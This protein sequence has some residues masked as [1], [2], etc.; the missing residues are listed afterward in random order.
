[1]D[2][3]AHR[4]WTPTLVSLSSER[5][6]VR[7]YRAVPFACL[8]P[9]Q[10]GGAFPF[11]FSWIS[12]NRIGVRAARPLRSDELSD[13]LAATTGV[14]VNIRAATSGPG[15]FLLIDVPA[16][17]S[18]VAEAAGR[19]RMFSFVVDATE[20]SDD[21]LCVRSD[22]APPPACPPWHLALW[23]PFSYGAANG[24]TVL[25]S[26]GGVVELKYTDASGVTS[27][28]SVAMPK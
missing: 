4:T 2:S 19:A 18:A 8:R 10:S 5:M 9:K 13:L 23:V 14:L 16:G 22:V 11:N 27:S 25:V 24:D 7:E 12:C 3:T 28:V 26:S 1:M 21:P 20:V 17:E 15:A 6:A